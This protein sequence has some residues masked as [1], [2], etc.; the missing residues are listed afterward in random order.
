[1][2]TWNVRGTDRDQRTFGA[3]HL[4]D[5]P[6]DTPERAAARLARWEAWADEYEGEAGTDDQ[7]S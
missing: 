5:F 6:A 1:V 2:S 3:S 4:E 7:P